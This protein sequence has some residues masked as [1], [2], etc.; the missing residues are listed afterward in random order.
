[1]PLGNVVDLHGRLGFFVAETDLSVDVRVAGTSGA[2]TQTLD[3]VGAFFG[4]GAGFNFGEHWSLSVDWTRYANVGDEN[5]D[6]DVS[7]E[8]GFDID[9]LSLGASFRF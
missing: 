8:G 4:V 7:T 6:D 5:E 9:A 2:D 3:S 1:L